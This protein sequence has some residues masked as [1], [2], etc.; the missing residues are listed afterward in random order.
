MWHVTYQC[1]HECKFCFAPKNISCNINEEK[2]RDYINQFKS[3]DVKK[4]DIS[5]GEPLHYMGLDNLCK[6][7][8][9][10]NIYMTLTTRG[11]SLDNNKWLIN[12]TNFFS[13]IIISLDV[14]NTNLFE[15]LSGSPKLFYKALELIKELVNIKYRFLRINTVIT[16]F[17]IDDNNLK[18][19]VE[20]VSSIGYCE[21]CL[22]EPHPANKKENF[23][24]VFVSN[25]QFEIIVNKIKDYLFN[26]TKCKII[27][28]YS[29]NY[30]SYWVLYPNGVI[31]KH[32]NNEKD[33]FEAHLLST[34]PDY[35]LQRV[36]ENYLWI[37][38]EK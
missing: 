30:S 22:I 36:N 34:Q 7:L 6:E 23:N 18:E 10:N 12:S 15:Q 32:T 38:E 11:D 29:S 13:R 25:T 31:A 37:P 21:W 26:N 33:A 5:G 28:R 35:I 17:L 16:S 19:M 9:K 1:N 20:F 24:E 3:L 2:I 4:V 8:K 14:P 27:I